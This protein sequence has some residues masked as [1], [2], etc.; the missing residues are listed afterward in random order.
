MKTAELMKNG[1]EFR[2]NL[3]AFWSTGQG[4]DDNL[5]N[6]RST[7]SASWIN[8][9]KDEPNTHPRRHSTEI[10]DS[11]PPTHNPKVRFN[12]KIFQSLRY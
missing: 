11:T 2:R 6:L 12:E 10:I 5:L 1:F 4:F 3:M 7:E 9:E 8:S